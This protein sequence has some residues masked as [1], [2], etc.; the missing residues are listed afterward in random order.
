MEAEANDNEI[1]QQSSSSQQPQS[2]SQQQ[3][4]QQTVAMVMPRVEQQAITAATTQSNL[5]TVDQS[6]SIAYSQANSSNTVTTT[7]AGLKRTRDVEG[8]SSTSL[9]GEDLSKVLPQV[10]FFS[11]IFSN[12]TLAENKELVSFVPRVKEL[13]CL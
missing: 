8:D 12:L 7:Q 3:Q 13:E 1:Q 5:Q 10:S 4:V 9:E 6:C 2:L 11:L